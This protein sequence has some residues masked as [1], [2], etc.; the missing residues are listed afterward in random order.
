MKNKNNRIIFTI[1]IISISFA[2]MVFVKSDPDQFWHFASGKYMYTHH[3]ILTHDIFSW[4]LAGKYWMSHEWLFEI[5]LYLFYLVFFDKYLIIFCLVNIF[6]L[7]FIIYRT[8]EKDIYKNKAFSLFWLSF[9]I[10]LGP[11]IVGRP[12]LISFILIALTMYLLKDLYDNKDSKKI[13]FLPLISIIWANIHGGSSNLVY[14]Y[15][16]IFMICSLFEFKYQ[17][18]E[19]KKKS[20][21]QIL[22]YLI[23]GLICML[24]IN[25]NPHGFKL[26]IYPYQNLNDSL[27]LNNI[28]EWRSTNLSEFSHYFYYLLLLFI[29]IT[30]LFSKKKIR[31]LDFIILLSVTYLGLRS[32]RFWGLTYIIMSYF[33]FYY[34]KDRKDDK[35]TYELILILSIILILISGFSY[36]Y[37]YKNSHNIDI[38]NKMINRIKYEKPRRLYNIYDLG[39]ELIYN[40]IK[41]FS[42]GRADFYSKYSLRD[43]INIS[44]LDGDYKE[45]IDYYNFDYFLVNNKFK[46]FNYLDDNDNYELVYDDNGVYLYKKIKEINN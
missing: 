16:F 37:Y 19:S 2:L 38:S 27:M 42:D 36:K 9:S 29:I 17:K 31:L 30:M 44:R 4:Y 40:D 46:I 5:I 8:N 39:G 3:K 23:I 18:I 20:K 35:Y 14:I 34:V 21:K 12:Q 6:I 22:T 33:I 26:F 7:L 10:I 15:T 24:T 41:V 32:V 1:L 13:Y 45:K 11:Y 28:S 43:I 25:I